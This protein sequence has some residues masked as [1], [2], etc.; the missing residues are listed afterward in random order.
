VSDEEH[1][2]DVGPEHA[3]DA[4]PGSTGTPLTAE[5]LRLAASVQ[6][7]AR[8]SFPDHREYGEHGGPECQWCPLCQ[9]VA[10][11]RGDRPEVTERV[12][13]AG[14]AVVAALR[15]LLDAAVGAADNGGAHR[16]EDRVGPAPGA[17]RVQHINLGGGPDGA[18]DA[19]GADFGAAK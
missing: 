9:F 1:T 13:E 17:G 18:D 10:V 16:A 7:W 8:R 6:D 11:L 12:A 2:G 5:A 14:A 15:G 3:D 4:P 19:P